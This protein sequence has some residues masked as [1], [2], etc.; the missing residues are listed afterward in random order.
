MS[1]TIHQRHWLYL[2]VAVFLSL[3]SMAIWHGAIH[4]FHTANAQCVQLSAIGHIPTDLS[5]PSLLPI[6]AVKFVELS[7][8]SGIISVQ[9]QPDNHYHIR[10]PPTFL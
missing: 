9:Q 6:F 1:K 8:F 10:A 7:I 4:S 3:Q 5:T 2:L